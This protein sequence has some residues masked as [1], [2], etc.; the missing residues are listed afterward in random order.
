MAMRAA[1]GRDVGGRRSVGLAARVAVYL[2]V[3]LAAGACKKA[4]ADDGQ[5]QVDAKVRA[6]E[7]APEKAAKAGTALLGG[8]IVYVAERG[9]HKS[10]LW[11]TPGVPGSHR[12]SSGHGHGD[13]FIAGIA[14]DG[15]R[16]LLVQTEGHGEA[17][18][19]ERLG[20]IG[21]DGAPT[22]LGPTTRRM[23]HPAFLPDGSGIVVESDLESFRDLYRLD[24]TTGK[25]TRLT[26]SKHG[27]FEP[28]VAPVGERVAFV[29]SD[30][31]DP[32][33]YTLD[34]GTSEQRRLTWSKGEDSAPTWSPDGQS[35]A[36]VSARTGT[37][38]VYVMGAAGEKPRAISRPEGDLFGQQ[39]A[40]WSPD[41]KHLAFIERRQNRAGLRVV[42]V[43]DGEV[44]LRTDGA[45]ID[46][47]PTFSPDG[48]HIAFASDRSGDVEIHAITLATKAVVQLTTSP[49]P[50]WLPR[51]VPGPGPSQ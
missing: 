51:W 40:C 27:A 3:A 15:K 5:G 8:R 4:S 46:E 2:S 31:G 34:L 30:D 11:L 22:T 47:Q 29:T 13:A 10:V 48:K 45:F 28:A 37:S 44:V 18:Q 35:I 7:P 50:D 9:E 14:P 6:N 32:E 19:R 17:A 21:W 38:L 36:F 20:L 42:R 39:D 49:G 41:G 1:H 24:A 16:L 26:T 12:L 43:S 25:A 23:R 33:I